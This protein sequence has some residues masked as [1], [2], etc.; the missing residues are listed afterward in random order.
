MEFRSDV[1]PL[2][3]LLAARVRLVDNPGEHLVKIV[4]LSQVCQ[5]RDTKILRGRYL[6]ET[7]DE[8]WADAEVTEM[9]P[10]DGETFE[11]GIRQALLAIQDDLAAKTG[12]QISEKKGL[13]GR[14]YLAVGGSHQAVE[15]AVRTL[16]DMLDAAE[17]TVA[18]ATPA[19][20]ANY[21]DAE[22]GQRILSMVKSSAANSEHFQE[23]RPFSTDEFWLSAMEAREAAEIGADRFNSETFG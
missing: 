2:A 22:A 4:E 7:S 1:Y 19:A 13:R 11:H 17:I 9:L 15:E 21:C 8:P 18:E 12:A 23:P 3:T 14:M 16:Q 6:Q 10:I 5:R 20:T